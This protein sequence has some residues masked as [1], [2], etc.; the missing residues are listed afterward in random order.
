MLPSKTGTYRGLDTWH[1]PEESLFSPFFRALKETAERENA[2]AYP[3][4]MNEQDDKIVVDAELP[5]FK[6]DEVEVDVQNRRLHIRAEREE[7]Q[8]QGTPH[9]R[10]R[11]FNRIERS[12]ALPENV[13]PAEATAKLSDGLLHI[14][15]PKQQK[16]GPSRIEIS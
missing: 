11:S 4:D 7:K 6:R 2:A 9:V 15:M 5:G 8:E 3:V 10:E 1:W 14:E 12:F 16:S 13:D